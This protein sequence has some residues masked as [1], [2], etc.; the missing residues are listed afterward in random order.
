MELFL[1]T[2][3]DC[4]SIELT[5]NKRLLIE[6]VFSEQRKFS[7]F[8]SSKSVQQGNDVNALTLS[9]EIIDYL[10]RNILRFV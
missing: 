1:S 4:S 7:L 9:D 5:K 2:L 3:I 8:I 10:T 6:Q